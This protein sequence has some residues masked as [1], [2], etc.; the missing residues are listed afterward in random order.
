MDKIAN[1][2]LL[3]QQLNQA[4]SEGNNE[5]ARLL[6]GAIM[7]ADAKSGGGYGGGSTP[8][9]SPYQQKPFEY[10]PPT[11]AKGMGDVSW[12]PGLSLISQHD[13]REANNAQEAH[14][15]YQS[16]LNSYLQ[17]Y[18]QGQDQKTWD[19][20]LDER[21]YGRQQD[22]INRQQQEALRALAPESQDWY[23]PLIKQ[24]MEA[25]VGATNR[26]NQPKP[27]EETNQEELIYQD[28]V[29]DMIDL[30]G[31]GK[32]NKASILEKINLQEKNN[33]ISSNLAN[34]LRA[35]IQNIEPDVQDTPVNP[36][37]KTPTGEM[38]GL[39]KFIFGL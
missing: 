29:I 9:Y 26:S 6:A 2:K 36:T 33:I 14:R 24:Q 31:A 10:K 18:Q 15:A 37:A 21:D 32:F 16:N 7:S 5:A 34:R 8:S 38:S 25:G 3:N 12:T 19:Y 35:A 4:I 20:R 13:A 30:K 23:L 39:A 28:T 17:D 22:L 27:Q 11:D 1:T